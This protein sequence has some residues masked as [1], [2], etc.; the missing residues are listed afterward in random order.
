TISVTNNSGTYN[1]HNG[2][3][4]L[5]DIANVPYLDILAAR[6]KGGRRLTLFCVN[7]DL[8]R[9]IPADISIASFAPASEARVEQLSAPSISEVNDEAHPQRVAPVSSTIKLNGSHL[10]FTFKHASVTRID[11][12]LGR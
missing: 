12:A 5:P 3:T 11:I 6:D 7:R 8:Q 4:R 2:V 10:R 9:D 1:V